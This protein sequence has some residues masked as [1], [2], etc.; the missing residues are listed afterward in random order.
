MILE[1]PEGMDPD[2]FLADYW[3]Q[4]PLLFRQAF[5]DFE[6]PLSPDELGGLALDEDI[7]SRLILKQSETQWHMR[8]GPFQEE[9]LTSL[10]AK[11][12]TLLVSD[13]DKQLDGFNR[14]LTFFRFIPDWRIDDLMISYAPTGAS[15]GPHLDAYDVFLFQAS[16]Q[17]QWQID[18]SDGVDQTMLPDNDIRILQHF[19]PTDDWVLE[20]GDMLYLPP[21]VPHHGV[22][23]DDQCM[24]WS[25]GFRAPSHTELCTDLVQQLIK[26]IDDEKRYTDG[27]LKRQEHPGEISRDAIAKIRQIFSKLSRIDDETFAKATGELLSQSQSAADESALRSDTDEDSEELPLTIDDLHHELSEDDAARAYRN[28]TARLFYTD[29]EKQCM[30]FANGSSVAA[31]PD[32]AQYLTDNLDYP[33]EKLLSHVADGSSTTGDRDCLEFL[34]KENIICMA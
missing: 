6:N 16:G 20:A 18:S 8:T 14:F 24:T 7:H 31:S 29:L 5:K 26:S 19:N 32:F 34:L 3:Q 12:W 4:K 27:Q 21:G 23:K 28:A 25:V 11:D 9:D 1:W 33:L 2:S 30:L 13:I 15:A 17:R 22:S 10:P